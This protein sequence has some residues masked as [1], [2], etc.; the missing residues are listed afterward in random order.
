MKHIL[1]ILL[2]VMSLLGVAKHDLSA[3]VLG[4][5]KV[6]P[7]YQIATQN[8]TV[9]SRVY[10][11]MDGNLL[12][13]DSEDESVKL[14][15][16]LNTLNDVHINFIA[17]S[18]DVKRLLLVYEN[19]NIDLLD[20]DDHSLNISALKDKA[21]NNKDVTCVSV[22]GH[23]AYLGT[24]FG[25]VS[26][27][28][29][30]G[31]ISDTYRLGVSV[32]C[33]AAS[34]KALWVGCSKGLYSSA[35]D[36]VEIHNLST[37]TLQGG[38]D[39][40][41]ALV[42]SPKGV[43][44]MNNSAVLHVDENKTETVKKGWYAFMKGIDNEKIC[45]G[46]ANEI[47]LCAHDATPKTYRF[48][49]TW[50]DVSL[51]KSNLYWVSEGNDGLR[52]YKLSDEGFVMGNEV[53]QPNSPRRD[54]FYR[55]HYDTDGNGGYRL[56]V[57]GGINTYL[58]VYHP[59]TAMLYDGEKWTYLDEKTPAL[60]YPELYHWNTSDIVQ[61]PANTN[62]H[63]ASPYRT[64]LYEYLDGKLTALYNCWNSPLQSILPNN[65]NYKNYVSATCL[66]YDMDGNL[67]MCN[68]ETDTII[69]VLT[70]QRKWLSLY[71]PEI[72]GQTQCDGYL[73][74][75]SGIHFLTCR[76]MSGRGFFGFH[77]NGTIGN[78][79]DDKHLLRSNIV[80][81][82]GTSYLPEDFHCM[83]EDLG[84]RIWCGT[85]RGLFV[86]D[87]PSKFFDSD[88][89][90]TQIKI[91]RDDGSGLADYLLNGVDVKCIAVDG[92]NRK[93][94]GTESDGIYLVSANGTEMLHHF[95]PD[96]SPLLSRNVQCIA[97]HPK[98]GEV[99]IGTDKGLCSFMGDATE[100]EDELVEDNVIAYP[101]PVRPDYTGPIR[102]D[103][104]VFDS[105]VKIC[106]TTGQLVWS[107]R[108]EGGTCTWNGCNQQGKRVASGIYHVVSNTPDGN[109]A[110]VT[111][112]VMIK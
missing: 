76:R 98:T 2:C 90:F 84:G 63:F 35:W 14:Y 38:A 73:F 46:N 108:S 53:I 51:G 25:V 18:A 16:C 23:M 41:R 74:S 86:I 1:H 15:D 67:W 62:H 107:G 105:E 22:H 80:N 48:S 99:M 100:A 71:Y 33:L 9:G 40:W 110:V 36:N 37:W 69:R 111:R 29:K 106:S 89:C 12:C 24:G 87:H 68:Q 5:W 59:A 61:D 39:N 70:P 66:E 77:T 60:D 44:A 19:E 30:E 58:G 91:S 78:T 82:D 92:G 95:L 56:L 75:S 112:I 7:S 26:V 85:N 101:N 31:V 57:A 96:D 42:T 32:S 21:I 54:L 88:F 83:V 49:N 94:I 93:W 81:Q 10:S 79:R 47:N 20:L 28:M 65:A 8:L 64:G 50:K 109:K 6:Y 104:L 72:A 11:L 45:F 97:V 13:Y 43:F 103:G 52:P 4:E 3:Q 27:D 102:I 17:Y 55:M 34:D